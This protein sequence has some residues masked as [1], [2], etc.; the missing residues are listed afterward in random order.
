M[1]ARGKKLR[2]SYYDLQYSW[3][4]LAGWGCLDALGKGVRGREMIM[5]VAEAQKTLRISDRMSFRA[6]TA[7]SC[8]HDEMGLLNLRQVAYVESTWTQWTFCPAS[9]LSKLE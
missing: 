9:F 2:N 3:F 4:P 1:V 7:D 8:I 6:V 5:R